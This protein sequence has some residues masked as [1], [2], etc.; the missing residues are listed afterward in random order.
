MKTLN[1]GD[2]IKFT[3]WYFTSKK[4]VFDTK[5]LYTIFSD[6]GEQW[7]KLGPLPNGVKDNIFKASMLLSDRNV[8]VYP[9][10][11]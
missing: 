9:I 5:V 4:W 1:V 8:F 2:S 11:E 6:D 3:H 10:G 7:V